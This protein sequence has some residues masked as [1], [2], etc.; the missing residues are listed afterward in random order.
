[1]SGLDMTQ[2]DVKRAQTHTEKVREA[3]ADCEKEIAQV[4]DRASSRLAFVDEVA[5]RIYTL[6]YASDDVRGNNVPL[7]GAYRLAEK[8]Y[9]AREEFIEKWRASFNS[10]ILA[11]RNKHAVK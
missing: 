3:K 1:M 8:L 5:M 10:E 7:D 6:P 11:I 4:G 2:E 9:E